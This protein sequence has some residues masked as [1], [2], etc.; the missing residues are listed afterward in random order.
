MRILCWQTILIS[1]IPYFFRK[2]GMMLQDLLS[3]ALVIGTL[4]VNLA[5]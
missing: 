1:I 2:L 5:L 4:R 3:A